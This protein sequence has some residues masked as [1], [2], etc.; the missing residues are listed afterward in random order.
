M[1]STNEQLKNR[2]FAFEEDIELFKKYGENELLK[3]LQDKDAFKRT[4]FNK[5]YIR[6]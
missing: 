2:G 3:L 6:I 1:K 4:I 5:V